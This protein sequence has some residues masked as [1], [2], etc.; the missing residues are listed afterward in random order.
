[1]KIF[2]S[3]FFFAA[4]LISCTHSEIK[5]AGSFKPVSVKLEYGPVDKLISSELRVENI[6]QYIAVLKV[7][8]SPEEKNLKKVSDYI[9]RN[10]ESKIKNDFAQAYRLWVFSRKLNYNNSEIKKDFISITKK[11]S[12]ASLKNGHIKESLNTLLVLKSLEP[13]KKEIGEKLHGVIR[14]LQDIDRVRMNNCLKKGRN[15]KQCIVTLTG[16][17]ILREAIYTEVSTD[18]ISL[19]RGYLKYV[20]DTDINEKLISRKLR[21]GN[22]LKSY[23][24][25]RLT[26][27][28]LMGDNPRKQFQEMLKSTKELN[29]INGYLAGILMRLT[30]TEDNIEAIN[31]LSVYLT[32]R[33]G[34]NI[35]KNS[36]R[37]YNKGYEVLKKICNIKFSLSD[38]TSSIVARNQLV[39]II[40]NDNLSL[41][42]WKS[43]YDISYK[44]FSLF[45]EREYISEALKEAKYIKFLSKR[46]GL[47]WKDNTAFSTALLR[48]MLSTIHLLRGDVKSARSELISSFEMNK[49]PGVL[50]QLF[51]LEFWEKNYKQAARYMEMF[52]TLDVN[53]GYSLY[54]LMKAARKNS[55]VNEKLGDFEKARRIRTAAAMYFKD[56]Y[57]NISDKTMRS[58]ILIDTG[59]LYFDLGNP[60]IA[61]QLFQHALYIDGSCS[62]YREI[63]K[64]LITWKKSGMAIDMFNAFSGKSKCSDKSKLYVALSILP[65]AVR[66]GKKKYE[67]ASVLEYLEKYEGKNWLMLLS[68]LVR[69]KVT[70]KEVLGKA[71]NLGKKTEGEFYCGLYAWSTGDEK[72]AF[73]RFQSTLENKIYNYIEHEMAFWFLRYKS[74][75]KTAAPK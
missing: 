3:S 17:N 22:V 52:S 55:I 41:S 61:V 56:L 58:R 64:A 1:M 6:P 13:E 28:L 50:S 66:D 67:Y 47:I 15:L 59:E 36:C 11:L 48:A 35:S 18:A 21:G 31:Q 57:K 29:E 16:D 14:W 75:S 27:L 5:D 54:L 9:F 37:L 69:G 8:N 53:K 26:G 4:L 23:L 46:A 24:V 39:D 49:S 72:Q 32:E 70:C 65:S 71:D 19:Y 12:D 2:L 60:E 68:G 73:S 45:A 7:K 30:A 74:I 33:L 40:N 34:V 62:N 43:L 25:D 20:H 44:R 42:A 51:Q 63:I 38:T 10:M